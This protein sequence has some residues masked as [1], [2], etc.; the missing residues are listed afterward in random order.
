MNYFN[1]KHLPVFPALLAL[2]VIFVLL[3]NVYTFI[4]AF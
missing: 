1:Q 2:F 4:M 3:L